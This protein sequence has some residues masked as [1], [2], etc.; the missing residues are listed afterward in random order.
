MQSNEPLKNDSAR[1]KNLYRS[2]RT[3]SIR[4]L[5]L[6]PHEDE[7][8]RIQCQLFEY[9]LQELGDGT[10]LYDALSYVWGDPTDYRHVSVNEHHFSVRANLHAALLR[11]RDRHFERIIWVDAIC[12]DQ[13][14]EGEK[15]EKEE[16]IL[17]M[18]EIYS[19]A[20]RVIVWLGEAENDSDQALEE[21]RLAA[22]NMSAEPLV[23]KPNKQAILTL[24][25]RPWFKRIWVRVQTLNSIDIYY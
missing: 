12:I 24:L 3:G 23:N 10:R 15:A 4:L 6:L 14:D 20:S 8:A 17:R 16:Q 5:R 2:L 18:A 7:N 25:H 11:L 22:D 9:P 1:Q 21:I 19:K 13:E